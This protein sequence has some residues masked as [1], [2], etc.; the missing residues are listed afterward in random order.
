[1][2]AVHPLLPLLGGLVAVAAAAA[3]LRTARRVR[4]DRGDPP[5]PADAIVVFGAQAWNGRPSP[6]LRARLDHAAL[7]AEQG[8][9]PLVV[10]SG[11]PDEVAAM[12]AALL[13]LGLPAR[14]IEVH[15]GGLSTRATVSAAR[16]LGRVLL[17]SSPWHVHRIRAEAARQRLRARVCPPPQSP[18]ERFGPARRRQLLREVVASWWYRLR[19]PLRAR[20]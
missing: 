12:R 16:E 2:T 4:L 18:I 1:V 13:R 8:W 17:V 10:C 5:A 7:L 14:S 9:A 6:E 3:A 11:G 20:A 15:A 19:S